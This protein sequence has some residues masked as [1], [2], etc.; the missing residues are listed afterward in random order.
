MEKRYLICE[1]AGSGTFFWR[2]VN[3]LLLSHLFDDVTD[4]GGGRNLANYLNYGTGGTKVLNFKENDTIVVILD[5]LIGGDLREIISRNDMTGSMWCVLLS[6]KNHSPEL[7]KRK[8]LPLFD[9]FCIQ[10]NNNRNST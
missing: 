7:C 4:F 2:C 9:D 5:S 3:R 6:F 10:R 8:F 1:D